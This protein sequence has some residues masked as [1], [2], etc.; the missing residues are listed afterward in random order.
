MTELSHYN[1]LTQQLY[2]ISTGLYIIFV[3]LKGAFKGT[4]Q[5]FLFRFLYYSVHLN[6][7][8]I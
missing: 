4:A 6:R 1:L 8:N 3:Y 7:G 5:H 2:G